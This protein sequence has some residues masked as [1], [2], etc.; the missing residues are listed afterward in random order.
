MSATRNDLHRGSGPTRVR[1]AVGWAFTERRPTSEASNHRNAMRV[2]GS[3]SFVFLLCWSV[4]SAAEPPFPD[5]EAVQLYE[6]ATALYEDGKF[7]QAV[8]T[9]KKAQKI[10]SEPVFHY[11]LARAYEGLGDL[12]NAIQSYEAY[13][14]E[15]PY[16]TDRPAIEKRIRTL[17]KQIEERKRLKKQREQAQRE[18]TEER[19]R[20]LEARRRQATPSVVPWIV[21]GVGGAALVASGTLSLVARGRHSEAEQEEVHKTALERQADAE[22]YATAANVTLVS[23]SIVTAV[24]VVW[25]IMDLRRAHATRKRYDLSVSPNMVYVTGSF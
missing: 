22:R 7:Q 2:A 3:I 11:N 25:G 13:L 6:R 5:A 1:F 24:G 9:L 8:D 17:K 23:G 10:Q 14:R 4:A 20:L 12:T 16:P 15:E 21:A 18:A 19:K